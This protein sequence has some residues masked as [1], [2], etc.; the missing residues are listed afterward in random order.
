M[1]DFKKLVVNLLH[2]EGA[3]QTSADKAMQGKTNSPS[4]LATTTTTGTTNVS[5]STG[6]TTITPSISTGTTNF[7][8]TKNFNEQIKYVISLL[9]PG[10]VDNVL[11]TYFYG[12]SLDLQRSGGYS[13]IR[14][15]QLKSVKK[16]WP[17]IDFGT[18]ILQEL[19]YGSTGRSIF[20]K[21]KTSTE[22]FIS[23]VTDKT[24]QE[25]IKNLYEAFIAIVS[26]DKNPSNFK[27]YQYYRIASLASDTPGKRIAQGFAAGIGDIFTH[28]IKH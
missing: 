13:A 8:I 1:L 17:I 4:S 11:K 25:E 2:E 19:G 21:L 24:I 5:P 14:D 26:K 22:P 12:M 20:D 7:D 27:N 23:V 6:T 28:M 3:L 18:T 15:E 16:Y 9:Y 10:E